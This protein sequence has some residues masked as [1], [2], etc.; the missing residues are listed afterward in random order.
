MLSFKHFTLKYHSE[1]NAKIWHGDKIDPEVRRHLLLIAEKFRIFAEI[2]QSAVKD[3]FLTGGLAN[4]LWN[5]MSD[6]DVHLLTNFKK[7]QKCNQDFINKYMM[8][9]KAI[10]ANIHQDLRVKGYPVE[11]YA[12]PTTSLFHEHQGVFS[13]TRNRWIQKP[14]HQNINIEHSTTLQQKVLFLARQIDDLVSSSSTDKEQIEKMRTK[15]W[16]MRNSAIASGGE[17]AEGN[18]IYKELR[19][20]GYLKILSKFLTGLEDKELSLESINQIH[21]HNF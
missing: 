5:E 20:Q 9:K 12:H 13:L 7:V 11:L 4:F 16:Q 21:L 18:L 15:I 3:V 17:F 1:L 19:N 2:P 6:L 14:T 10:W 8:D